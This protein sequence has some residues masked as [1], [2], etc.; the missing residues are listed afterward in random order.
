RE[1]LSFSAAQLGPLHREAVTALFG[2]VGEDAPAD[3]PYEELLPPVPVP[4]R[5]G[6][7]PGTVAELVEQ[8]AAQVKSRSWQGSTPGASAAAS[9][10]SDFERT[11]DG[12]VRLSRTDRA[13]L[14]EG[15]REAL[16][17]EWYIEHGIDREPEPAYMTTAHALALVVGSLLGR[18]SYRS[19]TEGKSRWTGT[20]TCAHAALNGVLLARAWEAAGAV[21]ADLVPF[22]LA[23]PTWH[24]GSLDAAELVER[25]RTYR[26]LGA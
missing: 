9:G 8:V 5:L 6:P 14:A 18:L 1:E 10:I 19:I 4:S 23:T 20:G 15:L 24:T 26:R 13:A 22:L 3:G 16:A 7:A 17:G 25:L 11:L 21:Q 2:A 12:L